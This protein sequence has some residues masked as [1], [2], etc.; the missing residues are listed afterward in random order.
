M[1]TLYRLDNVHIIIW[2]GRVWEPNHSQ[3]VFAESRDVDVGYWPGVQ[4]SD[5]MR[6]TTQPGVDVLADAAQPLQR[7][8]QVHRPP[9]LAHPVVLTPRRATRL[10]QVEHLQHEMMVKNLYSKNGSS[11]LVRK[12]STIYVD[13]NLLSIVIVITMIRSCLF[14][15]NK[16]VRGWLII[17]WIKCLSSVKQIPPSTLRFST[18]IFLNLLLLA[19][20]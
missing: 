20:S 10:W 13:F 12:K 11:W 7:R 14:L 19:I 6:V 3:S 1:L 5:T 2:Y 16:G 18:P 15:H 17:H 9:L 8:R 4:D